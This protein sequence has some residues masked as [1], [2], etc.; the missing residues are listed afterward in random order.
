VDADPARLQQPLWNLLKNAAKFTPEGGTVHVRTYDDGP[1][2]VAVEVSDTG[3]GIAADILPKVFDAFEQGGAGM[4]A[5]FGGL[6]LGLAI[7][8][9]VVEGHGGTIR[10]ASEGEGAGATFTVTLPLRTGGPEAANRE[11]AGRTHATSPSIRLLLVEDH[12]D[13]ARTLMRLLRLDGMD[14]RWAG[15]VAHAVG[16]ALSH[17]FDVIV[18]DVGLTDGTGL[19]LLRRLRDEKR[20]TPAIAMSGYGMDED[21]RRTREAGFAEHLVKPVIASHAGR[22]RT[23][24]VQPPGNRPRLSR[25]SS[26]RCRGREA[27]ETALGRLKQAT[28]ESFL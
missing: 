1:D 10:A 21:L 25:T 18:I 20:N 24:H 2:R 28:N 26:P 6:G 15:T 8:K 14:V 12:V 7:A 27:V 23:S 22:A 5:R 13:A 3:R 9:A 17:E 16:L 19:D 11:V 4:T